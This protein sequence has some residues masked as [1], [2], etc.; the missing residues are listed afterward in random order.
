M[1]GGMERERESIIPNGASLRVA[2]CETWRETE[3]YDHSVCV[4]ETTHE[5][6][7]ED[8]PPHEVEILGCISKHSI[9]VTLRCYQQHEA[10]HKTSYPKERRRC[11]RE[12]LVNPNGLLLSDYSVRDRTATT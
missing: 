2:E 5:L 12:G 10:P 7:C 9:A 4:A 6:N 11:D 8:G 1:E 3:I